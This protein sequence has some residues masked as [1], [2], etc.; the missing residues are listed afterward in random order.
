MFWKDK[1]QVS[2]V[3]ARKMSVCILSGHADPDILCNLIT[4][5]KVQLLFN[6]CLFSRYVPRLVMVNLCNKVT[7][8]QSFT[9]F[10]MMT[11]QPICRSDFIDTR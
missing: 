11:T 6:F 3:E 1:A 7:N 9:L 4:F 5:K 10:T 8:S 2:P